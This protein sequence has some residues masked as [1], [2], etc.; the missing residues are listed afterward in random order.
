MAQDPREGHHTGDKPL[1]DRL[2]QALQDP[3]SEDSRLL[4][5][6]V[7]MALDTAKRH[8]DTQHQK[9]SE[10]RALKRMPMSRARI[11]TDF[12]LVGWVPLYGM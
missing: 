12:E 8:R 3:T 1:D 11:V 2:T 6:M 5:R 10:H 7:T 9:A 4:Y